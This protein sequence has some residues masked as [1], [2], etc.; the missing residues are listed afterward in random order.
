MSISAQGFVSGLDVI[1]TPP[2]PT[3]FLAF[4]GDDRLSE[5]QVESELHSL[6]TAMETAMLKGVRV[7]VSYAPNGQQKILT[8]VR[9]L[10]R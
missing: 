9:L 4:V 2:S 3:R 7:E 6:Q 8:R 5:I 1:A 10:D